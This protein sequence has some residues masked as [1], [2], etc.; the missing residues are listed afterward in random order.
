MRTHIV[1]LIQDL[2]GKIPEQRLASLL[3]TLLP[4]QMMRNKAHFEIWQ[5]RGYHVTPIHYYE[6]IPDTRI[7]SDALWQG[8]SYA[9]GI[10][11]NA[12]G[13]NELL[14]LFVSYY[15]AEWESFP[16]MATADPHQFHHNQGVFRSVDAEILYCMIRHLS[17]RRIIE[18]GS[19]FSTLVSAAAI[20]KNSEER[21][22]DCELTCVEPYPREFLKAGLPGLRNFRLL[23]LPLQFVPLEYFD[24]LNELDILFIDS[25]HVMRVGSDVN[26]E[27]L[28]ILPRLKK[29]VVVHLHDIFLPAEYQKK[30]IK[31][32]FLFWN[33]QYLLHAFLQNNSAFRVLWAA[34]YMH[35]NESARLSSAFS[36]YTSATEWP[37][38]FWMKRVA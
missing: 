2:L 7:L 17:P 22:V 32:S 9:Q 37:G 38:S 29:G 24:Q 3:A 35:L 4:P 25:T 28:Q 20:R 19:G 13:Q 16:R 31:E 26:Y 1:K 12:K 15:R 30:W 27:F 8:Q 14:D 6:P 5:Q 36:S 21:K 18:I 10:D 23:S 33:E 34:S 11:F